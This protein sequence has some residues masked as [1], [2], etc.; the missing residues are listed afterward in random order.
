MSNKRIFCTQ[1]TLFTR[2]EARKLQFP[3]LSVAAISS[4]FRA[5]ISLISW[6]AS[7]KLAC[8]RKLIPCSVSFIAVEGN[9]KSRRADGIS[10]SDGHLGRLGPPA[11]LPATPHCGGYP[12]LG[13]I[14][15][16][17]FCFVFILDGVKMPE[18]SCYGLNVYKQANLHLEK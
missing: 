15:G 8:R 3:L 13:W 14:N 5:N 17:I 1:C 11:H 4:A 2:N 6:A 12:D 9:H 10:S 16:M 18:F 7:E